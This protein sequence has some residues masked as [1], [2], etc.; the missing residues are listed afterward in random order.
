MN[1]TFRIGLLRRGYSASG[2][3]ESYLKRLAAGLAE[4]NCRPVLICDEAWPEEDWAYGDIVRLEGGSPWSFARSFARMPKCCDLVLSFERVPG[5]DFFRAG[6]GVHAAWLERRAVFEPKWRGMLHRWNPKHRQI[7]TLEREL[8]RSAAT[9]GIIANSEMVRQEIA[10]FFPEA[11]ARVKV[12]RNGLG[13]PPRREKMPRKTGGYAVLFAGSGWERKGLA[14]AVEATRRLPGCRLIVAGRGDARRYA[15]PH[16]EFLGPVKDMPTLMAQVDVFL[17]PT[18]YDPFSNACLEALAAGLPVITTAAN[19]CGEIL[20]E[21]VH[22]HVAPRPDDIDFLAEALRYWNDPA[23][24][25]R[26]E[27]DCRSLAAE[28]S[29]ERNVRETLDFLLSAKI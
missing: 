11:V 24:R 10:R 6:D 12:I 20:V 21:K 27:A 17:L 9:R 19:G 2:G 22:G 1:S 25:Q 26:A 13:L 3:A 14:F 7:L 16:V 8:F 5:C 4:R 29:L 23:A 15:A 18:I 28:W